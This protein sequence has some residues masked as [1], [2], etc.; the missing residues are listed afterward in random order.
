MTTHSGFL[1]RL[2]IGALATTAVLSC[3]NSQTDSD[4]AD[5][6]NA[7]GQAPAKQDSVVMPAVS[8]VIDTSD[9]QLYVVRGSDTVKKYTIAVGKAK[10]PTPVGEFKIHQI[11]FN[12]DW[13]PPEGDWAK[14]K[15][16]EKPGSKNN[17]MGRVRI[18]YEKPYTIH[19]TKD[20][21]SLGE[22]ESHGSIRMANADVIELAKLLMKESGTE[23]PESWYQQVLADSTKMVPV[24]L[25]KDIRLTNWE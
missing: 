13:T 8:V 5:A 25:T 21:A 6:G 23:K 22:A 15:K 1:Y 12:P 2:L 14:N 9:K 11:D 7:Q 17:P 18:V 20:I 3:T 19:G 4:R 16:P 10:Y 24:E